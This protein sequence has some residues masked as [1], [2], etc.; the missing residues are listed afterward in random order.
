MK[1]WPIL[2][3]GITVAALCCLLTPIALALL[4][5]AS[6]RAVAGD[7]FAPLLAGVVVL[8]LLALANDRPQKKA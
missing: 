1:E 7:L 6:L 8:A 2:S 4:G 5:V 3:I